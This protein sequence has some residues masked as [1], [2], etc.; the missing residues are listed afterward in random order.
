MIQ[1]GRSGCLFY[2]TLSG[3]S[4]K[5]ASEFEIIPKKGV[6]DLG[7]VVKFLH[8]GGYCLSGSKGFY[9]PCSCVAGSLSLSQG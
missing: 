8:Q 7:I 6:C 1:G 3:V 9:I 2:C 5:G 4:E